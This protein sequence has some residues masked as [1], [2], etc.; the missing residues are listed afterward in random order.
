MVRLETAKQS[1]KDRYV[2]SFQESQDFGEPE[3]EFVSP[4]EMTDMQDEM[5]AEWL[6]ETP[7]NP[8]D[9][10]I[11]TPAQATPPAVQNRRATDIKEPET[12]A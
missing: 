10:D 3:D 8:P 11:S 9:A 2:E 4:H 1:A 12:P 5:P 7:E 6:D